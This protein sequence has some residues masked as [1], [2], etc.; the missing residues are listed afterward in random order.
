MTYWV[1]INEENHPHG[2]DL[3]GVPRITYSE[4]FIPI[5]QENMTYKQTVKQTE[6]K[7][8]RQTNAKHI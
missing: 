2:P 6:R 1:N 7:T 5:N 3:L 4:S 8:N